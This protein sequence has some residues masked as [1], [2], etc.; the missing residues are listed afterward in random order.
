MVRW[1][2]M[3]MVKIVKLGETNVALSAVYQN[4]GRQQSAACFQEDSIFSS[5]LCEELNIKPQL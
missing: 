1:S 2:S 3:S 4:T 5:E